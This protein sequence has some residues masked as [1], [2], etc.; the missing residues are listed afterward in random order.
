MDGTRFDA[1][2]RRRFGAVAGG[3]AGS[4]LMLAG[5]DDAEAKKKK[6]KCK[7]LG[8][9]CQP[10]GKRKCCHHNLCFAPDV[11]VH[12][13]GHSI[14]ASLLQGRRQAMHA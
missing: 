10:G 6:K 1:W 14:G 2:T 12:A 5:H 13:E 11:M 3:L 8:Q 7:K 9:P 4:L